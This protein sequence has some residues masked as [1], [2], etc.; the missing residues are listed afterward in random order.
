MAAAAAGIGASTG[1]STIEGHLRSGRGGSHDRGGGRSGSGSGPGGGSS[2]GK[3]GNPELR[4]P[5]LAT[6]LSCFRNVQMST[7]GT[8]DSMTGLLASQQSPDLSSPLGPPP[9]SLILPSSEEVLEEVEGEQG[10]EE[11]MKSALLAVATRTTSQA[12]AGVSHPVHQARATPAALTSIEQSLGGLLTGQSSSSSNIPGVPYRTS[13]NT[14]LYSHDEQT[15]MSQG[16]LRK[17]IHAN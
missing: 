1:V 16:T 14:P 10:E 15:I 8:C 2:S 13:I 3:N 11:E 12:A 7:S 4:Q 6:T 5:F 17:D 9:T